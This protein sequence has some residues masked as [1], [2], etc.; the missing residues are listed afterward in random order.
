MGE[1]GARRDAG[2]VTITV[3]QT[4]P[5][6][7]AGRL[8]SMFDAFGGT[9][10]GAEGAE[11]TDT[12]D[13]GLALCRAVVER[14]GGSIDIDRGPDGGI[15]VRVRLPAS[16]NGDAAGVDD[17]RAG[18]PAGWPSVD[19]VLVVTGDDETARAVW[20]LLADIDHGPLQT[21]TG[22]AAALGALSLGLPDLIVIERRL[23]DGLGDD[24]IGVV[25]AHPRGRS[26]AILML[27][28]EPLTRAESRLSRVGA[29]E[30]L[31]VP[32]S[33]DNLRAAIGRVLGSRRGPDRDRGVAGDAAPDHRASMT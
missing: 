2:V 28:S 27:V 12:L 33:V 9:R 8:E 29:T 13:V 22:V 16:P 4:G 5:G 15:T 26:T 20:R 14:S 7:P 10:H 23:P 30:A 3:R 21:V 19:R 25:R 17:R 32:T 24:V 11:P 1:I 6:L 31:S 18:L